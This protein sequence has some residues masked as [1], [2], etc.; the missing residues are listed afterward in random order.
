MLFYESDL[1]W[2]FQ[3]I[4]VVIAGNKTDLVR[5]VDQDEVAEWAQLSGFSKQRYET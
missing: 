5:E 2:K 4:P 3:D 1:I